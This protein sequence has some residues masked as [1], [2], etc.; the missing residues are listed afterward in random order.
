MLFSNI[1]LYFLQGSVAT[2]VWCGRIFNDNFIANCLQNLL[3]KII[4]NSLKNN[5]VIDIAWCTTFET[6]YNV[7]CPKFATFSIH[8][9][10]VKTH[11]YDVCTYYE[12]CILLSHFIPVGPHIYLHNVFLVDS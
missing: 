9:L 4:E 6:V 2:R 3:V 8:D 1:G 11:C 10:A 7:F 5:K 12:Y